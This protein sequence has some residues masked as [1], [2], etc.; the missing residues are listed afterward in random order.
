VYA[1]EGNALIRYLVDP[2][3]HVASKLPWWVTKYALATPLVVP[4]FL[5]AKLLNKLPRTSLIE[6]LPLY[7]YALWIAKRDFSFFRHVAFDQLVT[8]QTTYLPKTTIEAWLKEHERVD[9]QSTYIIKRNG[10][11]W[12]FGGK[13]NE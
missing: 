2:I 3:R 1:R 11:S 13:T 4:F 7:E 10:N 5:Y 8:P 9:Q 6:K 12:K